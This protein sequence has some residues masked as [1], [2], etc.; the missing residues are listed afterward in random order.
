MGSMEHSNRE[1]ELRRIKRQAEK[2][3]ENLGFLA[4][5]KPDDGLALADITKLSDRE[6]GRAHQR[7]IQWENYAGDR[8]AHARV[9][10]IIS[11]AAHELETAKAS[12]DLSGTLHTIKRHTMLNKRVRISANLYR[13]DK[14]VVLL[15]ESQYNR[16]QRIAQ[17]I[18]REQSR[19]ASQIAKGM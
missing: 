5:E 18:S 7:F 11:E 9:A 15:M 13:K 2:R 19:R 8:V 1:N 16:F 6:L 17:L 3:L 12:R 14:A 4:V 10:L